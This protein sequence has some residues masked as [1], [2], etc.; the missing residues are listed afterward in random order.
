MILEQIA[1]RVR[2]TTTVWKSENG[3]KQSDNFSKAKFKTYNASNIFL[4][5]G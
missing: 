4:R 1:L 2:L 5:A 3:N